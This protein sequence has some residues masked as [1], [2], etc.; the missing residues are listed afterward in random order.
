MGAWV[1]DLGVTGGALR[2]ISDRGNHGNF[3]GMDPSDDWVTSANGLALDFDGSGEIN[4]GNNKILRNVSPL[5]YVAMVYP[6]DIE[7]SDSI[8]NKRSGN[9]SAGV[10]L[11]IFG[12]FSSSGRLTF[13]K[14]GVTDLEA[15][16]SNGVVRANEWQQLGVTWDGGMLPSGVQLYRNG[17]GV[18]NGFTRTGENLGSD[19]GRNLRI[20]TG[21]NGMIGSAYIFNRVLKQIEMQ[22]LYVDHLAPFRFRER[23]ILSSGSAGVSGGDLPVTGAAS[24][25]TTASGTVSQSLA[26]SGSATSTATAIGLVSAT[27]PVVGSATAT[28]TAIGTIAKTSPVTGIATAAATAVG[29]ISIPGS[30]ALPVTGI[31]TATTSAVGVVSATKPVEGSA[32][33][34]ATASGVIAATKS[35]VGLASSVAMASGIISQALAVTGSAT[36]DAT[37]TGTI[38][39]STSMSVTGVATATAMAVGT[40]AQLHRVMG[41]ATANATAQGVI[42]NP[43]AEIT[44]SQILSVDKVK[45]TLSVKKIK[46]TLS[47]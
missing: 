40:I 1:P 26:V 12:L 9:F 13:A 14:D 46:R 23:I 17:R 47:I 45:R 16:S 42:V 36:A 4:C 28:S 3:V 38:S 43:D 34:T 18:A 7:S 27:K 11:S 15:R 8:F 30:T 37:A 21:L 29:V 33:A 20:G 6:R 5:T 25:T 44:V 39:Q 22:E 31:A 2:D 19:A 24:A 41:T 10:Q 32:D 35:V